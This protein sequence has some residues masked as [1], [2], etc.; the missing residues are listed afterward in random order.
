MQPS[1]SPRYRTKQ[2]R[3]RIME[4]DERLRVGSRAQ[5]WIAGHRRNSRCR[6]TEVVFAVQRQARCRDRCAA[7]PVSADALTFTLVKPERG[8]AR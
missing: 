1:G 4:G 5:R 3:L 2:T 8:P 7:G 6:D